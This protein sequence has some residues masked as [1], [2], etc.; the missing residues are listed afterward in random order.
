MK[1]D[2]FK[3]ENN[4]Q[5]LIISF[6]DKAYLR[7]GTDVGVRDVKK[8][9]IFDVA[10]PQKQKQ[11]PQHDFNSEPKVHQTPSSFRFIRGNVENIG[12]E[13][14]FVHTED[15]T[16]VTV[17]PKYFIGSSGSVWAS[18]LLKIKWEFPQLFEQDVQ[19]NV[20]DASALPVR[21]LCQRVHDILFYYKDCTLENDVLCMTNEPDCPFRK[22]EEEKLNWLQTQLSSAEGV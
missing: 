7:P 12:E 20:E 22:Y 21:Q 10:D 18:D 3:P 11:L 14:R 16:V 9:V 13:R 15:Q 4:N 6:D 2:M 17:R 19:T 1:H 5:S 8:G